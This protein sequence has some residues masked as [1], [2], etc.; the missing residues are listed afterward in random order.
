MTSAPGKEGRAQ[1]Y[2]NATDLEVIKGMKNDPTWVNSTVIPV[3]ELFLGLSDFEE[4]PE[5]RQLELHHGLI[6]FKFWQR[7]WPA[8][9]TWEEAQ[10][11]LSSQRAVGAL[12][13]HNNEPLLVDRG[14]RLD[15]RGLSPGNVWAEDS[16]VEW[17]KLHDIRV[18]LLVRSIY[19]CPLVYKSGPQIRAVWLDLSPL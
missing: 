15:K 2:T 18:I 7:R 5:K 16:F 10:R 12:W 13:N 19:G 14:T 1:P 8:R 3:L 17:L 4:R 6:H 11:R 9:I